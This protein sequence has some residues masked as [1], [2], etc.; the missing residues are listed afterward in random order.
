MATFA[1]IAIT[2]RTVLAKVPDFKE[3]SVP[4]SP[5][6]LSPILGLKE[7]GI[8]NPRTNA[9]QVSDEKVSD[10]IIEIARSSRP[11]R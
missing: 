9:L 11:R 8:F 2:G 7:Q 3:H 4:M 5:M 6:L 10:E 1:N